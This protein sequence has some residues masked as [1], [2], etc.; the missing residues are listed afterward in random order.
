MCNVSHMVSHDAELAGI[1]NQEGDWTN[2]IIRQTG[3]KA[4]PVAGCHD[5]VG[6]LWNLELLA[7]YG[8]KDSG[9]KYIHDNVLEPGASIGVHT[10]KGD[11]EVYVIL[12]GAGSMIV[13][14]VTESVTSGDVCLTRSGHSH[15][16]TNGPGGVMHFLVLCTNTGS[17]Q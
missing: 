16:L 11:E 14:G 15:G 6:V 10:H 4:K 17:H 2:M 7:E 8:K 9:F 3:K 5:G 1:R 13:D 12:S